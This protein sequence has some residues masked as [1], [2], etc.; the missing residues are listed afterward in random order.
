MQAAP[1]GRATRDGYLQLLELIGVALA[2]G[3]HVLHL[4]LVL[5]LLVQPLCF[6]P[7]LFLLSKLEEKKA[8]ACVGSITLIS[9]ARQ[10]TGQL[11][12]LNRKERKA[13]RMLPSASHSGSSAENHT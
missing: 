4:R 10:E 5:L 3:L 1:R 11:A 9:E 6:L 13:P 2:L 12:L 7:L 8:G